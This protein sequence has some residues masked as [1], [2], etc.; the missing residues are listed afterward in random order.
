[1]LQILNEKDSSPFSGVHTKGLFSF[2]QW[3]NVESED[4][5]KGKD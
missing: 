1:M 4:D 2:V 3:L 5:Q